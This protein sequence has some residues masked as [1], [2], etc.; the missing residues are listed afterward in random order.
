MTDHNTSLVTEQNLLQEKIN[1]LDSY[2]KNTQIRIESLELMQAQLSAMRAYDYI[3]SIR[4][5][6]EM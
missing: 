4:R 5:R 2:I 6:K 1:K 3:L